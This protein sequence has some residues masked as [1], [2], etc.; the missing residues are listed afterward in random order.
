MPFNPAIIA[1]H[2]PG[3]HSVLVIECP[4]SHRHSLASSRGCPLLRLL[5]CWLL[6]LTFRRLRKYNSGCNLGFGPKCRVACCLLSIKSSL[7]SSCSGLSRT[8]RKSGM[9]DR[10]SPNCP[11]T[12]RIRYRSLMNCYR[13]SRHYLLHVVV[14]FLGRV[15]W[16]LIHWLDSR[17]VHH[18]LYERQ[19]YNKDRDEGH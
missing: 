5:V 1:K 10:I 9:E 4:H 18:T 11:S 6:F 12:L 16:R 19:L 14:V 7:V 8:A 13:L 3:L 2:L 17:Q 15:H